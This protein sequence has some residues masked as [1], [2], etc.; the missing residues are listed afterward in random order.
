MNE[1]LKFLI[2]FVIAF[3][4]VFIFYYFVTIKQY[5]KIKKKKVPTEVNL[6]LRFHDIKIEKIN[7]KKMLIMIACVTS[8]IIAINLTVIY[9]F[10]NSNIVII[11]VTVLVSLPIA[12]VA[13]DM[14]G[15]HFEK[16]SKQNTK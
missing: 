14:I 13:Y 5:K 9:K 11:L 1:Y 6:I 2:E 15:K 16:Q 3:L 12:L 10:T 7:Y 8:F 4:V